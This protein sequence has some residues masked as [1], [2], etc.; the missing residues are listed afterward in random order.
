M[1][2]LQLASLKD[3][4][5]NRMRFVIMHPKGEGVWADAGLIAKLPNNI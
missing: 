3:L 5:L 2:E 1:K 4:D